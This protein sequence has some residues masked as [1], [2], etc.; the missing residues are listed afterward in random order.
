MTAADLQLAGELVRAAGE[1]AAT[2]RRDGVTV[3]RKTSI[4]DIVTPADTAAEELVVARLVA[5]RPEDGIV[6]EEGARRPGRRTWFVDPVDGTYNYV[7]GL[8]TWCAAVA[9]VDG[10]TLELGAVFEPSSG[11]LF[12]GGPDARTTV[13]GV[14]VPPLARRRLAEVSVATY[15]H[16]SSSLSNAA[17]REPMIDVLR[18]AASVRMLGSGS[19]E[20]AAVAA[21][22][23]GVYVQTDCLPWDWLPGRALVEGAGGRTE[24]VERGGHRWHIAGNA[25]A[26]ADVLS[27]L[28]P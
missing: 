6:A 24:V 25:T 1:L 28:D 3:T 7:S 14:P 2:M 4:S 5:E 21:G 26:V 19:M 16:P 17:V 8:A 22:R 9:L 27:I 11:E 20:L 12:T 10:E 15:L 13:N 23:I 18:P